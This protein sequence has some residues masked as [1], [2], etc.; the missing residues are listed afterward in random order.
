M[1]HLFGGLHHLFGVATW[2]GT[3]ERA[4]RSYQ[5]P[6]ASPPVRTFKTILRTFCR[7]A[8]KRGHV[9]QV[10]RKE[11][12]RKR[13][14]KGETG[15]REE[16]GGRGGRGG[17]GG[18]ERAWQVRSDKV[19]S[20]RVLLT[21]TRRVRATKET[22]GSLDI[23]SS[24]PPPPSSADS[25]AAAARCVADRK[26]QLLAACKQ[27]LAPAAGSYIRTAQRMYAARLA[28]GY[29][30]ARES[31]RTAAIP[32]ENPYCSCELK[33]VLTSRLLRSPAG[34]PAPVRSVCR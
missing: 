10:K 17:Q 12:G 27:Q 20:A 8:P 21:H 29:P 16:A 6:W 3:K 25:A 2:C 4:C 22:H 9:G 30:V 1:H 15:G 23:I 31:W 33:L 34:G 26:Q 14:E 18:E 28:A 24:A 32:M 13:R 7:H 19:A 11:R 5:P